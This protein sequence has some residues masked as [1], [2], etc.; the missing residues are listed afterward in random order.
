MATKPTYEQ[1]EQRVRELEQEFIDRKHAE[2]RLRTLSLAIE[3]S[4][5]GIAVADLKGT[6]EY[7]NDAVARMHNSLVRD[8]EG[9]QIGLI[10]TFRD[11]SDM[12]RAEKALRES[13]ER[14]HKLSE[15]SMEGIAIID[16]SGNVLDGNQTLASIFG[17]ELSELIGMNR[18]QFVP[19]EIRGQIEKRIRS[20][21]D[22]TYGLQAIRKDGSTFYVEIC[23]KPI[24]YKGQIARVSALRDITERKLAEDALKESEQRYRTLFEASPDGIIIAEVETKQIRYSNP[25]FCR[26]LGYDEDELTEIKLEDIHPRGEWSDIAPKFEARMRGQTIPVEDVQC[27]KKD[28]SIRYADIN[29]AIIPINDVLCGIGFFRDITERKQVTGAL[30]ES[31]E[32]YRLFVQTAS[33][34]IFVAQDEVLRFA[35]PRAEDLFGYSAEELAEMPFL[36]HIHPEDRGMVF[37]A[38]KT[39]LSGAEHPV[40]LSFRMT[41]K[42]GDELWGQTTSVLIDW[43]QRPACLVF[44]R[45]LTGQRKLEAQFQAAQRMESLGTLAGGIAHDFNNLLMGIQ[46]NASLMLLGKDTTHPDYARLKNIEQY[47]Q[48]AA[49]L[50]QQLLGLAR[51]GKYELKT[52]N[53]ND[54]IKNTSTMFARTKKEIEVHRK[55]QKKVWAVEADQGQIEQVLLNLY[56]NAWQAMPGGGELYLQT[57]NVTID[58][59]YGKPYQAKPGRYVKVSIT[60]TGVGMDEMTRQKIFEPFFTTKEMGRGTGLGLA[61]VYGIVKNHAGFINVYSVKGEGTTFNIY[62]PASGKEVVG[63]KKVSDDVSRGTGTVLLVDDEDM[64]IDV[65]GQLLK[66][67]GYKV[68]TAGS[69]KEAI[70]IYKKNRDKIDIVILDMVMPHMSGGETYDRL[71]EINPEVRVLLSSGYSINGMATEILNRGCN[72]FIQK[73]FNIKDLSRKL[74]EILGAE[75]FLPM[76]D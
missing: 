3:Q 64:I 65:G 18:T 8:E 2:E 56:V 19:P 47:V 63:E 13:E 11:I 10:G 48:D 32:R 66:K 41:N 27:L 25:A 31:E 30:R 6:L 24:S 21:Y 29:S 26:M 61:S 36:N 70:R 28:G 54:V 52:I 59:D 55:Y 16:P 75:L 1:L 57:E 9:N 15:A 50:T 68:R 49:G 7:L 4:N 44:L 22:E 46:G 14:F 20:G 45:D 34:A 35:N 51:G 37:D 74:R 58:E 53:I 17:Y 60:D 23:G 5:E 42:A 71:N 67:L 72:G 73:P 12:K 43:E 76:R 38:Y 62:L 39:A 40:V 69:G 33:D